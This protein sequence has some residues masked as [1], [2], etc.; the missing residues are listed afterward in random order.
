MK[1]EAKINVKPK[2]MTT[3][4]ATNLQALLAEKMRLK[5]SY[6]GHNMRK[7]ISLLKSNP[8]VDGRKKSR[9]N[10]LEKIY[11]WVAK[12]NHRAFEL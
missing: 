5:L 11:L 3:G 9:T 8:G 12:S 1:N 2:L 7:P 4:I 10:V 6:L